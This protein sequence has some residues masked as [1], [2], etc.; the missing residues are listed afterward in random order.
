M[1]TSSVITKLLINIPWP[2]VLANIWKNRRKLISDYH[3]KAYMRYR[4]M[5]R[6]WDFW[7]GMG[8]SPGPGQESQV[9]DRL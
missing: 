6:Y 8:K 3:M 4:S 2:E 9:I 5:R 7:I 1:S